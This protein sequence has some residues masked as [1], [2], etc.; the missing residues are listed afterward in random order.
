LSDEPPRRRNADWRCRRRP[1]TRVAMLM[2]AEKM[3]ARFVGKLL[4]D[5]ALREQEK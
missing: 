2:A 5:R 4:L 1:A 3:P